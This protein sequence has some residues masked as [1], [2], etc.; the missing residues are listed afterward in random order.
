V[1]VLGG[2]GGVFGGARGGGARARFTEAVH[3]RATLLHKGGRRLEG[4]KEQWE[5]KEFGRGQVG[6]RACNGRTHDSYTQECCWRKT[7]GV[8]MHP[9]PAR[10]L[11][12]GQTAVMRVL[13]QKMMKGQR[14][15]QT[16]AC[17]CQ[18]DAPNGGKGTWEK[19]SR[20]RRSRSKRPPTCNGSV[21]FRHPNGPRPGGHRTGDQSAGTGGEAAGWEN[22]GWCSRL[23]GIPTK[24]VVGVVEVVGLIQNSPREG[25]AQLGAPERWEGWIVSGTLQILAREQVEGVRN[26]SARATEGGWRGLTCQLLQRPRAA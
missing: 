7:H 4:Y 9:V 12:G 23:K 22:G 16:E 8:H 20:G 25:A 2:G 19:G 18:F 3:Q 24:E 10:G 13:E 26:R 11:A 21:A 14:G 15:G 6:T 1:G 5:H 17:Y